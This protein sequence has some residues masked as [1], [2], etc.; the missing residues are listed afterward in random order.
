MPVVGN[1]VKR[2]RMIKSGVRVD[3]KRLDLICYRKLTVDR[4]FGGEWT[5]V[6]VKVYANGREYVIKD[7]ITSSEIKTGNIR[8]VS[9][10]KL[11]K[12]KKHFKRFFPPL[13]PSLT[14]QTKFCVQS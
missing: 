8:T 3:E 9:L 12:K 7:T 4:K 5:T 14:L 13:Q 1:V 10:I 6:C 2:R 11:R